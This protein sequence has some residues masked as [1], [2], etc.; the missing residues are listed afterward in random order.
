MTTGAY[1]S[2][3]AHAALILLL[4]FGGL[5]ERRSLPEVSVANVSVLSE[6]QFAALTRPETSPEVTTDAAAPEAPESE[7]DPEFEAGS[8][9]AP[10]VSE[11]APAPEAAATDAPAEPLPAP[12]PAPEADVTDSLPPVEAPPIVDDRPEA[13]DEA[14]PAPA[15]RVAPEPAAP[16]PPEAEDAPQVV[17]QTTPDPEPAEPVEEEIAAAPPEATTEIV[18]E[19]EEEQSLAPAASPRPRSR[20]ER[21][22]PPVRTAET[23]RET[24]EETPPATPDAVADALAAALTGG[25]TE[26][27]P[28]PRASGPSGPPMTGGERD[29]FRVAVQQCWVVDVGSQAANVTVTVAVS[30]NPDGTVAGGDVRRLSASGGDD[31]A[32]RTAFEAARRAILRCQKGGYPLPVDKY[33]QWRDIEMTFN[34]EGMRLK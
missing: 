31:A 27:A 30:M 13:P 32:Q 10:E 26:P 33:D 29:A 17:E 24:P 5:L 15:P 19:A 21:P 14:A 34:P 16:A 1:I 20:P 4:L 2:G 25:G 22:A 23:P 28:P 9:A 8:D 11:P 3:A 12:D 6:E 18:T 7:A